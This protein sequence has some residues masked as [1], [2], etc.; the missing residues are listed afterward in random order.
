MVDTG[1]G[2]GRILTPK[3]DETIIREAEVLALRQMAESVNNL[4]REVAES[5]ETMARI[6]EDMAVLKDRQSNH[7]KLEDE[8]IQF[9]KEVRE[10]L[11][12]LKERNAQQDG[13]MTFA[14][15]LKEFGPW[16][17]GVAAV[18]WTW[19]KSLQN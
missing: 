2:Q 8:V 13:A 15:W 1:T 10:E 18:A 4:A 12:A 16:I 7:E 19:L 9:K 6:R 11:A 17:L 5:R 3:S 14:K